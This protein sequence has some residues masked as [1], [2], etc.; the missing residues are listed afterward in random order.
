MADQ[1]WTW[2]HVYLIPSRSGAGREVQQEI[3][4]QL[5]QQRWAP[6]DI[7]AVHLA[8]EEALVNAIKHGNRYNANKSVR[9]RC[10]MSPDRMRI[11]IAEKGLA[12]TSPGSPTRPTP[13]T[14]KP[15]R[16]GDHADA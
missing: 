12:S 10:L 3:L 8:M 11:E 5:K 14:S 16:Q 2:Q 7:F 9:V 4:D 15:P 6:R 13:T 1:Q